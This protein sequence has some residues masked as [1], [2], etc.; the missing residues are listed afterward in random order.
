MTGVQTCALPIS[1]ILEIMA[2][3]TKLAAALQFY[4][5]QQGLDPFGLRHSGEGVKGKG[6]FGKLPNVDGGYSTEISREKDGFEY[7]LIVPTLTRKELGSLLRGEEPTEKI[8]EK[9]WHFH[10]KVGAPHFH[11]YYCVNAEPSITYYNINDNIVENH[12]KN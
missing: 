8:E 6:Y 12:N 4:S 1:Q 2:E 7:P 5:T 10:D 11:G 9:A 3:P